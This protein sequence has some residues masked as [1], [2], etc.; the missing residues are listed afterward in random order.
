MKTALFSLGNVLYGDD[1]IGPAILHWLQVHTRLPADL[2]VEDLGTP[3]FDLAR[4]F[5]DHDRVLL[6]DAVRVRAN[7]GSVVQLEGPQLEWI[8]PGTR[9]SPHEPVLTDAI[10]IAHLAGEAPREVVLIGV[11]PEQMQLGRLQL[12]E[13]VRLAVEPAA[14]AAIAQLEKWGYQVPLIEAKDQLP[15]WEAPPRPVAA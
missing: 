14:R 3:G 10:A 8:Q 2:V 4:T 6:L 15:W 1:A 7:V 9:L 5:A 12:S 11:V 13:H